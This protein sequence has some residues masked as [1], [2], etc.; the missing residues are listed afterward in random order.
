MFLRTTVEGKS[1]NIDDEGLLLLD[2]SRL[3]ITPRTL[4][5]GHLFIPHLHASLHYLL[6]L[7]PQ[8]IF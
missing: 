2:D 4:L 3:G 7:C 6:I 5:P 8:M 1:L